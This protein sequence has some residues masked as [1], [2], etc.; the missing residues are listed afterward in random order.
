MSQT[1][2][3]IQR[4]FVKFWRT[5]YIHRP[6][7]WYRRLDGSH[8]KGV[9]SDKTRGKGLTCAA[10]CSLILTAL[11]LWADTVGAAPSVSAP[12]PIVAESRRVSFSAAFDGTNWLVG[13]QGNA[14]DPLEI[15]AQRVDQDGSLVGDRIDIGR[16]GGVPSV[17]FDGTNYLLVWPDGPADS[18]EGHENIYGQF[19]SQAGAK[20]GDPFVIA[21][22]PCQ[23]GKTAGVVFDGIN[24]FVTWDTA[25]TGCSG[26]MNVYGRFV[27]PLGVLLGSS[28][29]PITT[30]AYQQ[31]D[32][33]V[34]F[35]GSRILV[36][37]ADA[38]RQVLP[39]NPGS[40]DPGYY[41]T[42]IYGQ[43][44]GKSATGSSGSLSG[45]NFLINQ[46]DLPSDDP[47]F[48]SFNGTEYLVAWMDENSGLAEWDIYGQR[49]T[50][51]GALAGGVITISEDPGT[52]FILGLATDKTNWL[53]AWTD[54]GNDAN[55][56]WMCDDGEGTCVDMYGQVVSK[57][58]G[59]VGA[60][61]PISTAPGNQFGGIV[62]YGGGEFLALINE[63]N[64]LGGQSGSLSGAWISVMPMLPPPRG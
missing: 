24:Y 13:L 14:E 29:I 11:V 51:A 47:I 62:G 26:D 16:I 32:F 7:H 1:N 46:N 2:P 34:A 18:D 64:V 21:S 44:V 8:G 19:I 54:M 33:S 50:K 20:V 60:K 5:T 15:A 35:D 59:L 4:G 3:T 56:N 9:R 48:V 36:V 17:G 42:D 38:R 31:R 6:V 10:V 12:F 30:A 25:G 43:F 61:F 37:W 52:Q 49:V 55:H 57:A 39:K 53:L 45:S 41:P 28:Q 23:E 27:S 40:P 58:G 22:P 63:V